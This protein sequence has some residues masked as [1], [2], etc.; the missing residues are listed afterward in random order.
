[1]AEH[2]AKFTDAILEKIDEILP[3]GKLLDPF[4]GTGKIHNIGRDSIGVEIEPEWANMHPQNIV[5]NALNLPF[6][7]KVFDIVCCSPVYGNRMSD[8]HNAKDASKRYTYTHILGRKLH[9]ENS[10]KLQW[11]H[12]YQVFHDNA[13][14]ESR[15]VLRTNGLFC[16]NVKDHIRAKKIVGVS[17][18]HRSLLESLNFEM[19]EHHKIP[20][21]GMRNGENGELRVDH[22]NIYLFRKN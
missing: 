15:R 7:N 22:E 12:E 8:S 13:W 4:A 9:P 20:V 19:I 1:M 2:P 5:G 11:G 10:G 6:G 14:K 17:H 21:K 18:W 16:L 3:Q